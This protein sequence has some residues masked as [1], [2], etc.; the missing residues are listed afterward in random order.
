MGRPK[1]LIKNE[2]VEVAKLIR[3]SHHG[4]LK[5]LYSLNPGCLPAWQ[6]LWVLLD[7]LSPE[8]IEYEY[9]SKAETNS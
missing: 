7:E 2:I 6:R 3:A 9:P 8:I 4:M 5:A 1:E